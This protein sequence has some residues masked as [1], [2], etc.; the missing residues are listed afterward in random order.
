MPILHYLN[1]EYYIFIEIDISDYS[2]NE[3]F[4]QLT[5]GN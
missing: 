4:T 3:V 2:I 5:L 1:A